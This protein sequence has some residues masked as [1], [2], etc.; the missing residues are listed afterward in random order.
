MRKRPLLIRLTQGH[1][2]DLLGRQILQ[3]T[4]VRQPLPGDRSTDQELILAAVEALKARADKFFLFLDN[5]ED[6]LDAAS[7]ELAPYLEGFLLSTVKA[8]VDTHII[9]A[10]TRNPH[11][12]PNLSA[13][14]GV[15]RLDGLDDVYIK[16]SIDLWLEGEGSDV[17]PAIVGDLEMASLAKLAGG[18]PLAAKLIASYLKV[19]KTPGQLLESRQKRRFE[20]KLAE[21]II[22]SAHRDLQELH[23]LMLHILAAIREPLSLEDMLSVHELRKYDLQEIHQARWELTDWFLIQQD[24]E[25][26]YLHKFLGT[27][28]REELNSV[29]GRLDRIAAE[30]GHYA[31]ERA[32]ESSGELSRKTD[33]GLSFEDASMVQLS[34][35]VLRYAVPAG[36]L[37]RYVGEDALADKLP[38]QIKGT[39]REMV[40]SFYQEK[41]TT[42]GL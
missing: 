21:Y 39:L 1:S 32:I 13:S 11:Y 36:K 4:H 31:H 3:R 8:S 10:T 15:L 33:E 30:F 27:Y 20:L 18:H 29:E 16:E 12:A 7:N 9:I 34:N 26:M 14:A 28:F 19:N 24:G 17:H 41:K 40:F 6:A 2:A 38:M 22:R 35:S 37:L 25:L 23:K 42:A 5:A